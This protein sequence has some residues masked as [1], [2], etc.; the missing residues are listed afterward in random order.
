MHVPDEFLISRALQSESLPTPPPP[1]PV[2]A[3]LWIE[4]PQRSYNR[5]TQQSG[6]ERLDPV[7][8]SVVGLPG[9]NMG[10]AL[11]KQ[12]TGLDGRDK[13]VLNDANAAIACRLLVWLLPH[14]PPLISADVVSS[15][16]GTQLMSRLR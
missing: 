4:V 15:S 13:P 16:P 3:S 5:G 11:R 7:S 8:F 12:F 6:F 9:I 2:L 14:S 10:D 1:L